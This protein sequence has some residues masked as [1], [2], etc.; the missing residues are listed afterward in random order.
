MRRSDIARSSIVT[1]GVDY[2]FTLP[3][4]RARGRRVIAAIDLL[5]SLTSSD[6]LSHHLQVEMDQS[7]RGH[8]GT[9]RFR[10]TSHG[11][12]LAPV[13]AR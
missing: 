12:V 11:I 4:V 13:Q 5:V 8:D 2:I 10:Q 6:A 9:L 1:D 3:V 7:L